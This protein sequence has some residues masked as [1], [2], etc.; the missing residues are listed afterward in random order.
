MPANRGGVRAPPAPRPAPGPPLPRSTIRSPQAL[1][2]SSRPSCAWISCAPHAASPPP[3]RSRQSHHRPPTPTIPHGDQKAAWAMMR[4]GR[5]GRAGSSNAGPQRPR[6]ARC[7][8][9]RLWPATCRCPPPRSAPEACPTPLSTREALSPSGLAQPRPPQALPPQNPPQPAAW[10]PGRRPCLA[11]R[12]AGPG[13]NRAPR[14]LLPRRRASLPSSQD[15]PASPK[16]SQRE[17][18]AQMFAEGE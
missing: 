15:R 11:C 6:C 7:P 16:Q 13:R 8:G 14:Q 2:S 4:L 17:R 12:R 3:L 5:P 10:R 1:P 18:L 9:P